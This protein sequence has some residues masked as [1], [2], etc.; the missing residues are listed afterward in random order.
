MARALAEF[1][2]LRNL[3]R[4]T[5]FEHRARFGMAR[6][7]LASGEPEDAYRAAKP[8]IPLVYSE[9]RPAYGLDLDDGRAL[10]ILLVT[11]Y[12]ELGRYEE[13]LLTAR[14]ALTLFHDRADRGQDSSPVGG[15]SKLELMI[16]RLEA[17]VGTPR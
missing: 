8:L 14:D 15:R 10:A 9:A 3:G 1:E 16:E 4:G 7:H 17:R 13:A 12:E 5:V 11:V 2:R 6:V